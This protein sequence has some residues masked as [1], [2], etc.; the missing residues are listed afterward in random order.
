MKVFIAA[1]LAAFGS[2]A[3]FLSQKEEKPN[4]MKNMISGC[5]VAAFAGIMA[6]FVSESLGANQSLEYVSAG[7]FGWIGPQALDTITTFVME[8]LCLNVIKN[9]IE[10]DRNQN[11]EAINLKSET[12]NQT[13]AIE[14]QNPETVNQKTATKM[15]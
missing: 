2:L 11:A 5:L 6:H 8:R 14:I 7:I 1:L 10:T 3:R 9:Q 13:S 4:R 12:I 15:T